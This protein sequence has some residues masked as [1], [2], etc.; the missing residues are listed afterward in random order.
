MIVDITVNVYDVYTLMAHYVKMKYPGQELGNLT[1][2]SW[3]TT[4]LQVEDGTLV[5]PVRHHLR[6]EHST[7][8]PE[9]STKG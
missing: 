8:F 2:K 7:L 5:L 3:N 4:V 1:V 9:H 6:E